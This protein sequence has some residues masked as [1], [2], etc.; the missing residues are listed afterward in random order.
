MSTTAA[1]QE[2]KDTSGIPADPNVRLPDSV[3]NAGTAADELHRRAYAKQ[4][5]QQELPSP[6]APAAPA[7]TTEP[8][9]QAEPPKQ[10]ETP[11]AQPQQV[12]VVESPPLAPADQNITAEEWRHR[13]LSMQGRFNAQK[14][15]IGSMETQMAQLAQELQHVQTRLAAYEQ[16]APRQDAPRSQA[17]IPANHEKLITDQDRTDYGDELI[18][19]ARRAGREAVAPELAALKAENARLTSLVQSTTKREL[20]TSLDA[21][22]P[23]WRAINKD[24]R[25]K[26]WLRLPNIYTGEVRSEMLNRAVEAANAPLVLRFFQDFL[27]EAQATGQQVSTLTDQQP[28]PQQAP[29]TPAVALETLA[30]PGK[31]K[32]AQGDSTVPS[33]KPIYTRAQIAKFY[34]DSRRGLYDGRKAEYEAIQADLTL[35][36]REGRIR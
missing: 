8:P 23:Q 34:D 6:A 15:T 3:R 22:L 12:P 24:T 2:L 28:P 19:L 30:A 11:P 18:D 33:E 1:V 4:S 36:Q 20:F 26:S 25:F 13:F 9:K 10:P 14:V 32:P 31:A 29:R 5:T 35:A 7:A 16:G 27:A 21:K 17:T